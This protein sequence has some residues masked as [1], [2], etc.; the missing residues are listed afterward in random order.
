[1]LQGTNIQTMLFAIL[2]ICFVFYLFMGIYSYKKDKKSKINVMFFILCIAACLWAIGYAFM[3]ISPNIE[4]AYI[5]RIT[6]ALGWCFFNG[7]WV[8]FTFS[9]KCTN[10]K[11]SNSKIQY[12]I[13]ITL[14]IFFINNL[15]YEPFKV[16]GSEA[17]GFV[18]NLYSAT[19]IGIVFWK[20]LQM[21]K[22][23]Q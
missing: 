20:H 2:C 13:Y 18:S 23:L 14:I 1:M 17:Y 12:L 21:L 11:N 4:I 19:T 16:V 9:L 7:I 10:R 15:T 22:K 6:S 5:W 8:S 3:L